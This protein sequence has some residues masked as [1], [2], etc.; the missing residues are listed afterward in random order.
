MGEISNAVLDLHGVRGQQWEGLKG[1]DQWKSALAEL[2]P[3][4]SID[5]SKH[6]WQIP[7]IPCKFPQVLEFF[8]ALLNKHPL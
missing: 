6:Q 5:A 8:R 2:F 7:T 4:F 1:W 3:H